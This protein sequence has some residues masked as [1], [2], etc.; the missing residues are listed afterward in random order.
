MKKWNPFK[1]VNMEI[2]SFLKASPFYKEYDTKEEYNSTDKKKE[3]NP[4]D[5]NKTDG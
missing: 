4:L 1:K 2:G 5:D 3:D